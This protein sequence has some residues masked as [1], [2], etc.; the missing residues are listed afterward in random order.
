MIN[1]YYLSVELFLWIILYL[2]VYLNL[3][4]INITLLEYFKSHLSDIAQGQK[5]AKG[6]IH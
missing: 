3:I 1:K 5:G 2:D 6:L 4:I